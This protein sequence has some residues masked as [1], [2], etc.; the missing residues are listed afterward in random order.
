MSRPSEIDTFR[1]EWDREAKST[2]RVLESLPEDHYDFRPDPKGRSIGEMAWHLAEI[3]YYFSHGVSNRDFAMES[4]TAEI[5]RPRAI[6]ELAPR[7]QRVHEKAVERL[8]E[9]KESDL[10]EAIAFFD[11]SPMPIRHILWGAILNHLIHHRGQLILMSRMAGGKP[12][13][14]YGPNRE[15]SDAMRQPQAATTGTRQ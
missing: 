5:E 15:E 3:D 4:K 13:G 2:A 10:D 1:R 6:R 14:I 9:L 7:Y 11:G 8:K 12:P